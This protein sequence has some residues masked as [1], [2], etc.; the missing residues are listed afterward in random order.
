[1][2]QLWQRTSHSCCIFVGGSV[3]ERIDAYRIALALNPENPACLVNLAQLLFA[4]GADAEA[5]T[6]LGAAEQLGLQP[7]ASLEAA[8]YRLAHVANAR[9]GALDAIR[10]LLQEGART[11]WNFAPNVARV[12]KT[13]PKDAEL[14]RLVTEVIA[15]R[16]PPAPLDHLS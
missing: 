13:R 5:A 12:E 4:I 11:V 14:L 6:R 1:M 9:S 8:F 2:T 10:R 3:G 16:L 7:D 15:G